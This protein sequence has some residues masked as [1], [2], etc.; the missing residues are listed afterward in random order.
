MTPLP[1]NPTHDDDRRFDLLVDG[2]LGEAE[3]RELLTALE[4]EPGG[5][6]RCA[7]AFL[8]SQ[9]WKQALGPLAQPT[10]AEQPATP[11]PSRPVAA[12]RLRLGGDFATLAAMAGCFLVALAVGTQLPQFWNGRPGASG[13]APEAVVEDRST[14]SPK[15]VSPQGEP[16]AG[17]WRTVT[18]SVPDGPQGDARAIQLPAVERPSID[19]AWVQSLPPTVRPELLRS[20]QQMGYEVRQRRGLLPLEMNDGRQLVVPVDRVEVQYVGNPAY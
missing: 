8:E 14:G 13:P 6:R 4:R 11:V 1:D 15:G 10:A 19:P 2:E 17:N 20:L 18:L 5:W 3:R 16:G 7:L 12:R 9:C